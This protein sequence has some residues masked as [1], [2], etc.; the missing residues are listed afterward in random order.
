MCLASVLPGNRALQTEMRRHRSAHFPEPGASVKPR[1][2]TLLS[3][4][5]LPPLSA[6]SMSSIPPS[7]FQERSNVVK[8]EDKGG[9][10]G[11]GM[12]VSVPRPCQRG[13]RLGKYF[14]ACQ[15]REP[16]TGG[17]R[18]RKSCHSF[19]GLL[20]LSFLPSLLSLSPR[21]SSREKPTEVIILSR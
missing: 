9:L 16:L 5:S 20:S 1:G 7:V 4:H 11:A 13:D 19:H 2:Q 3:L 12:F 10:S 17:L 18:H 6:P 8:V 21:F 15:R 14:L